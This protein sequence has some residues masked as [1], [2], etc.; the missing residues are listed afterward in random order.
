VQ[1]NL[2]NVVAF[3]WAAVTSCLFLIQPFLPEPAKTY[4][5][6]AMHLTFFGG[7]GAAMVA[8][9][10]R[11]GSSPPLKPISP[12]VRSTTENISAALVWIAAFLVA[13]VGAG[14][15]LKHFGWVSDRSV[16]LAVVLCAPPVVVAGYYAH[17]Y[18]RRASS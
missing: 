1:F 2:T 14:S 18:F 16:L 13:G 6:H 9:K 11:T 7:I 17:R 5:G 4:V 10:L 8:A 3:L 15:A 12:P